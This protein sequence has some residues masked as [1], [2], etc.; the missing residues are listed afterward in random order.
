MSNPAE[1]TEG[2]RRL[3]KEPQINTGILRSSS[4]TICLALSFFFIISLLCPFLILFHSKVV[5]KSCF[6][7]SITVFCSV[8]SG[9]NMLKYLKLRTSMVFLGN[10]PCSLLWM[11]RC[12]FAEES[13]LLVPDMVQC[14]DLF[15]FQKGQCLWEGWISC[16]SFYAWHVVKLPLG[17]HLEPRL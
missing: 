10:Q 16:F 12:S 9:I 17:L 8:F 1:V 6:V 5:G 2:A 7:C 4:H 3:E 14:E 13:W 11:Q 15:T